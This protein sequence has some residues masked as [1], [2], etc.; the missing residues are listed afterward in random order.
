MFKRKNSIF[1]VDILVCILKIENTVKT[2]DFKRSDE[3]YENYLAWDSIIREFEIIGEAMNKLIKEKIFGEDKRVVVDFRNI[4]I[5]QYFGIDPEEVW[6]II[7]NDLQILKTETIKKVLEFDKTEM[8]YVL[9]EYKNQLSHLKFVVDFL[10]N[11]L[12][13]IKNK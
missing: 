9:E 5:H 7:Q 2:F 10:G 6:D 4:L 8:I 3:L 13:E 11:L 12:S 1:L